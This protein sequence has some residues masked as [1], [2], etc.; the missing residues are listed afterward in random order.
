MGASHSCAAA[1][2]SSSGIMSL[3]LVEYSRMRPQPVQVRLQVCSGSS[4]ST[5]ANLGVRNNL[6]L[7]MWAAI[8]AVNASGNRICLIYCGQIPVGRNLRRCCRLHDWNNLR[9]NGPGFDQPGQKEHQR[10]KAL[11]RGNAA[12]ARGQAKNHGG[13]RQTF[14]HGTNSHTM[15][16][17]NDL[18]FGNLYSLARFPLDFWP[19][20]G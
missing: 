9:R 8:F 17:S 12:A 1:R 15:N 20:I 6:C 7:T 11:G 5:R 18:N 2:Q 4:C 14:D 16:Y 10:R 13:K 3:R 19:E